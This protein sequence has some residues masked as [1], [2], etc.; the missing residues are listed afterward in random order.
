MGDLARELTVDFMNDVDGEVEALG[1]RREDGVVGRDHD[2]A[3]DDDA[4]AE[5]GVCMAAPCS[6]T[7]EENLTLPRGVSAGPADDE[8]GDDTNNEVDG[9]GDDD[10]DRVTG[11]AAAE[12]T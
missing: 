9:D 10:D 3:D 6:S 8:R 12:A 4:E 5:R 7:G 1:E 11:G 2:D